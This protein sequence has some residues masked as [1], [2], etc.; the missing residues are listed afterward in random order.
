MATEIG[1]RNRQTTLKLLDRASELLEKV[2]PEKWRMQYQIG[3]A[4]RYCQV[5]SDRCF[6][7]MEPIIRKDLG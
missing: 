6:T 5:K 7:M 4:M 1:T 2:P 3:I